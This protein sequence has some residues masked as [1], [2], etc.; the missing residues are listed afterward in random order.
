MSTEELGKGEAMGDD[1]RASG[2]GGRSSATPEAPVRLGPGS[3][4]LTPPS[5]YEIGFRFRGGE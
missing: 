1:R 2:N 4:E 5:I 3:Q